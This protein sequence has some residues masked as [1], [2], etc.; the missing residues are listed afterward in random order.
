MV[1]ICTGEKNPSSDIMFVK[2]KGI[3]TMK[4]AQETG[5]TKIISP[6]IKCFTQSKKTGQSKK[7]TILK[8]YREES[9]MFHPKE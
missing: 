9:A 6:E 5:S 2:A 4:K 1:N 8:V 7:Q 3:A